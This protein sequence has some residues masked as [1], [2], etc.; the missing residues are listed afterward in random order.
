LVRQE[1][2]PVVEPVSASTAA[3]VRA[4]LAGFELAGADGVRAEVAVGLAEAVDGCRA[5]GSAAAAAALPRLAA[6]LL[7]L[8]GA[9]EERRDAKPGVNVRR[10]L[11]EVIGDGRRN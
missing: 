9:M 8:L 11:E 1:R 2:R 7:A 3:A 5:S 4:Y 6:E 10:L